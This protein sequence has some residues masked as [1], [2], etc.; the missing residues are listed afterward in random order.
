MNNLGRIEI[1][2]EVAH[3][4][5]FAKAATALGMTGPAVSKQVMALEAELGV[6]LLH[7]TTRL[8]S[9]TD[10]GAIYAERAGLAVEELNCAAASL[11]DMKATPSGPL[12]ISVPLS[13]AQMHLLPVLSGFAAKYPDIQMDV[14]LED[15]KV[16]IIAE[17]FDLAIRIGPLADSSLVARS[18]G[19]CP[20]VLVASP[21]YLAAFG[22]PHT[23]TDLKAH[24]F[25][26]FS[27]H[28][29]ITEWSYQDPAGKPG[30]LRLSGHFKSNTAEMMRQAAL[31]GVG[32][33]LLPGF[34]VASALT[35][36]QLIQILPD[37][38][39]AP[40]SPITAL[41]P[42]NRYRSTK[43]QLLLEWVEA[44]CRQIPQS[45]REKKAG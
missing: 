19:M 28:G 26:A 38:T 11:Q 43:I 27:L 7:R 3:H 35:D 2:L 30:T 42:P 44:A 24:R 36:G 10:E 32:I 41:M 39:T 1:F 45:C 8:V 22:T 31:D 25:I 23:P 21:A 5:S 18:L 20:V 33:A 12:R 4:R 17:G 16:D 6:K 29:G 9:L 34:S 13:F 37:H 15:R 14:V 40:Q